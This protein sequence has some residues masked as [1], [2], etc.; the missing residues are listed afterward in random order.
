MRVGNQFDGLAVGSE[1]D[2]AEV[3]TAEKGNNRFND[4]HSKDRFA[5][6]ILVMLVLDEEL[7][8]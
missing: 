6:F 5:V 1:K 2:N 3:I 8:A 7:V 4:R